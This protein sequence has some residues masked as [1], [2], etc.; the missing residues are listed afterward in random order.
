MI[1]ILTIQNYWAQK[2]QDPTQKTH[3]QHENPRQQQ[4]LIV[5]APSTAHETRPP[6]CHRRKHNAGIL[7]GNSPVPAIMSSFPW[8]PSPESFIT[9]LEISS[10]TQNQTH[11]SLLTMESFNRSNRYLIQTDK[12]STT[13][14]RPQKHKAAID[15]RILRCGTLSRPSTFIDLVRWRKLNRPATERKMRHRN[16]EKTW[17]INN[18][19]T[20]NPDRRHDCVNPSSSAGELKLKRYLLS[21]YSLSFSLLT[22]CKFFF[23]YRFILKFF[24]KMWKMDKQTIYATN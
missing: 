11:P 3:P 12:P 20:T 17:L 16:K 9:K 8:L 21:L 14:L 4:P 15:Q 18:I 7:N 13:N 6:L 5:A 24:S 2:Q 22:Q 1:T 23:T 10:V 19:T